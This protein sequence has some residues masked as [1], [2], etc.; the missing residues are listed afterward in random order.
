MLLSCL[1]NAMIKKY[2]KGKVKKQYFGGIFK[3]KPHQTCQNCF[4]A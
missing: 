3:K 4:D 2:G 1:V